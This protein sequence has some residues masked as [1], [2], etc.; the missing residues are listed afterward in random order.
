MELR[1]GYPKQKSA[2]AL[3]RGFKSHPCQ[4]TRRFL[5]GFSYSV[6]AVEM[7]QYRAIPDPEQAVAHQVVCGPTIFNIRRHSFF[8][9]RIMYRIEPLHTF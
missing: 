5:F 8:E 2:V 6:V 3:P 7:Y 4:H 9:A 1:L